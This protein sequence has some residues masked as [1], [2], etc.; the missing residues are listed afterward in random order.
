MNWIN[1]IKIWFKK[2][3][4][5]NKKEMNS[6][7]SLEIYYKDI[8]K[9]VD[10][11]KYDIK[12]CTSYRVSE[13][14]YENKSLQKTHSDTRELLLSDFSFEMNTISH[15]EAITDKIKTEMFVDIA[16]TLHEKGVTYLMKLRPVFLINDSMGLHH[17]TFSATVIIK[18]SII[19]NR[20]IDYIT[21]KM[22]GSEIKIQKDLSYE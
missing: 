3:F 15:Y 13:E 6:I 20:T 10:L 22:D 18:E 19:K 14:K 7:Y 16:Q 17:C 11:K 4:K 21:H 5:D 9:Y 12:K 8:C 1:N 2:K